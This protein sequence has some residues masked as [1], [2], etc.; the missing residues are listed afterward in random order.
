MNNKLKVST[1]L[2][3]GIGDFGMSLVSAML[4]FSMLFYYTDVVGVNPGLAGTA[5]LVGKLCWDMVNDVLF[6]YFED[7]TKSRWG[8]RRPYLI[9]CSIPFA[10]AFWSVFSIPQGLGNVAYFFLIIGTFILFDT[11]H[12]LIATAYSSMTA[13]ITSDYNE[14]TSLS[15]YRMVFS[16]V[17]YLMGAGLTSTLASVVASSF[18][19]SLHMGWSIVSFIFGLLAGLSMLVPGL[20]LNYKPEVET[21]SS[22]PPLKSIFLT[23]KNK[24]FRSFI[25][26]SMI[27]SI[28]FTMVTTMLQYYIT[29]Q[30]E[31]G[32]STILV[33][34]TMLGV[35]ALFLVPCGLLSNKIGK[36]KTYALGLGIASLA[37]LVGFF[38]PQGK[39]VVIYILAA[40]VGLGF[41]SQW[42]CP[43]SMMP[44]VI[45]YDELETNERREGVYYGMHATATKVTGALASAI[46]GWGLELG[47]YVTEGAQSESALLAIRAM[48]ALIPAIF[49]I[50]CIPL[51]I[52]YPI[53]KKSHEEVVKKLR[54]RR[55]ENNE[56]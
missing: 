16:I 50:I 42:V 5:M 19:V 12:T 7:K 21:S 2:K 25:I 41:S 29:H 9:F 6:G 43:H 36:A 56:N 44:D 4:S 54:E 32:D 18:N 22:L 40:I 28:S 55:G 15:T 33:M 3:Y 53:T 1:K 23:L 20:F 11:F 26:V 52:K 8:K 24:P 27:M 10:L 35:L 51:L 13:E 14:R 46:C 31:M 34:L 45:E 30:L 38:L 49:L 48:F 17:G 47:K 39:S 37:L